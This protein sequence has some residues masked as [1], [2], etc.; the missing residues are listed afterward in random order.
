M[1]DQ[2]RPQGAA[3]PLSPAPLVSVPLA[4]R[5]VLFLGTTYTGKTYAAAWFA[6]RILRQFVVIV[7]THPDPSYLSQLEPGRVRFVAVTSSS[8]TVSPAFLEETRRRFRYLYLSVYDLDP[9]QL[10]RFLVSLVE[11]VK[12]TGNLA[13]FIDEAHLFCSRFLVPGALVGFVRG[14]RHFG[15][16]IILVTQRLHDLDVGLR[17]VL[18]HLVVFRTVEALDLSILSRQLDLESRAEEIRTLPSRRH[19]F[20]NRRTGYVSSSMSL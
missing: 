2:T 6:R 19:L 16:D 20:V 1:I 17:C 5:H 8:H 9:E 11:S 3:A 7:H 13:L 4:P 15:C 12:A 18:T 10:D 14:A